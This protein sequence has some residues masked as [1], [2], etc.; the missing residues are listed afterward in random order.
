MRILKNKKVYLKF[1]FKKVKQ[2]LIILKFEL[3]EI[4]IL[5][6]IYLFFFFLEIKNFVP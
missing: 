3:F 5:N 2:I 1:T 4:L 6:L